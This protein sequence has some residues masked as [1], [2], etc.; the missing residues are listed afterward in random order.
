M[1]PLLYAGHHR[2]HADWATVVSHSAS[3]S[4]PFSPSPG[5]QSALCGDRVALLR[6]LSGMSQ[7]AG[8]VKQLLVQSSSSPCILRLRGAARLWRTDSVFKALGVGPLGMDNA[9]LNTPTEIKVHTLASVR[10][11]CGVF[12]V[13]ANR[14]FI[15]S[16]AV[17]SFLF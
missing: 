11:L 9:E 5:S 15:R 4:Y 17:L 10:F 7:R 12:S 3:H 13:N 6:T 8:R 2:S 1:A 14:C 16:K